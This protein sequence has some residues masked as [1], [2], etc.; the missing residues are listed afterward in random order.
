MTKIDQYRTT[1]WERWSAPRP[2]TAKAV[3][4]CTVIAAVLGLVVLPERLAVWLAIWLVPPAH[5]DPWL[6]EQVIGSI[7]AASCAA[8]GLLAWQ[9]IG[10]ECCR[11][12]AGLAFGFGCLGPLGIVLMLV[13]KPLHLRRKFRTLH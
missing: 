12:A 7:W 10:F 1:A 9:L 3:K 11:R 2:Y 13:I 5:S 8:A 6:A 4:R